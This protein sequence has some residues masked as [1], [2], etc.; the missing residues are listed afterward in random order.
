MKHHTRTVTEIW[1]HWKEAARLGVYPFDYTRY[2]DHEAVLMRLTSVEHEPWA[3]AYMA[4]AEP[5]ERAAKTAEA[6]GDSDKARRDY[7]RASGLYRLARWPVCNS[8]SKKL[9]YSKSK[10]TFLAAARYFDPPLARVEMPFAG[11]SGEGTAVI[12]YLRRPRRP[13]KPPVLLGWG[14][15]D[16][17]KEDVTDLF[18][19]LLDRG[20]ATLIIDIP[21]TADAPVRASPDAERIWD[22]AIDWIKRNPELDG[23]RTA[24]WGLSTGGYWAGKVA[25]TH[26]QHFR[27][28]VNHGG[29]AH[30][31]LQPH[32]IEQ[33]QWGHYPFELAESLAST[34]GL[35]TIEDWAANAGKL[36]LLDQGV[37]DR[38]S[39]PLLLINGT[40]DTV[41]SVRDMYLLLEHGTPKTARFFPGE[42]MGIT[43]ETMPMI[44]DWIERVLRAST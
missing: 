19:P 15:L 43:A 11:R 21:G 9:A 7:L 33:A 40:A 27:G 1:N 30:Y 8:P 31:T 10:E 42:H 25:H 16:Y 34:I 28:V 6:A 12:G 38:P 36:S 5:F 44:Y 35:A 20:I 41:F 17:Y 24:G 18:A 29:C 39:A 4:A 14:G 3:R 23:A 13:A 22:A 2:E 32:W 37:L 26:A